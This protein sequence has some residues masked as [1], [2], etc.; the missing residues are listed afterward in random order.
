MS[1]NSTLSAALMP[2]QLQIPSEPFFP[3]QLNKSFRSSL[4]G[5]P[6]GALFS[7][8]LNQIAGRS[9]PS[10][11]AMRFERVGAKE[12]ECKE[13]KIYNIESLVLHNSSVFCLVD[14]A[15][16]SAE[17]RAQKKIKSQSA[18]FVSLHAELQQRG[19]LVTSWPKSDHSHMLDFLESWLAQ[20]PSLSMVDYWHGSHVDSPGVSPNGS[21]SS[22]NNVMSC[23]GTIAYEVVL[24]VGIVVRK[25]EALGI[26]EDCWRLIY[27]Q[28][29]EAETLTVTLGAFLASFFPQ[30]RSV[31][32]KLSSGAGGSDLSNVVVKYFPHKIEP[33][34]TQ[35]PRSEAL[36]AYQ[37]IGTLDEPSNRVLAR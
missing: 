10:I 22:G 5:T 31:F 19:A 2:S 8:G 32:A 37:T 28:D 34:V 16:L 27:P 20:N 6:H 24:Q 15:R 17:E 7:G 33:P 35:A 14:E 11:P 12:W 13:S 36:T 4:G 21:S 26:S 18:G 3:Q 30:L 1:S 25:N 29:L 23:R 9:F